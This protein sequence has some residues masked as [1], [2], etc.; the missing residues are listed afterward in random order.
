[1]KLSVM[2]PTLFPDLA[3]QSIR[4]IE[5][6]TVGIDYEI[7]VVSPIPLFGPNIK[8]IKEDQPAGPNAAYKTAFENASGEFVAVVGDDILVQ[9]YWA[10]LLLKQ[11]LDGEIRHP[12]G[13]FVCSM[14]SGGFGTVFGMHFPF[15]TF[16]RRQMLQN[17]GGLVRPQLF[18]A[19]WAD[20]DL[21]MRVWDAGG[22]CEF[23]KGTQFR[24]MNRGAVPDRPRESATLNRDTKTFLAQ[25]GAKYRKNFDLAR[26]R[27]FLIDIH[28]EV[29]QWLP[30]PYQDM[31]IHENT[32]CMNDAAFVEPLRL[33]FVKRYG[34]EWT[35]SYMAAHDNIDTTAA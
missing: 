7:V 28:H 29:I 11:A 16:A 17:L 23:C 35:A 15:Y 21:G 3:Q 24:G 30:R 6:C 2:V 10:E 19:D 1:M 34:E 22:R 4:Q 26:V 33:A 18:P 32:F 14:T 9:P 8:W 5:M 13:P 27:H 20:C 31:I 12:A 25:W